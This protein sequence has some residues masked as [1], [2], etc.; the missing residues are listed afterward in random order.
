VVHVPRRSAAEHGQPTP[1]TS[2]AI[3]APPRFSRNPALSHSACGHSPSKLDADYEQEL[4]M[5]RRLYAKGFWL[6]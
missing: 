5:V 2:F 1:H 6:G 3:E 4:A